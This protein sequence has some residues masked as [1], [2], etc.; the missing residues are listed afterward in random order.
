MRKHACLQAPGN[1][2]SLRKNDCCSHL[3]FLEPLPQPQPPLLPLGK[4][5]LHAFHAL[6]WQEKKAGHC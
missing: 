1:R 5:R 3:C 4:E 2:L 6:R